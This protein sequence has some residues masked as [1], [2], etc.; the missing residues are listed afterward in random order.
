MS[1]CLWTIRSRSCASSRR[2]ASSPR[3]A[4]AGSPR[5]ASRLPAPSRRSSS[6]PCAWGVPFKARPA[7]TIRCAVTIASPTQPTAPHGTLF[8]FLNVLLATAAVREGWPP[9]DVEAMLVESDE[10]ALSF[11]SGGVTWRGRTIATDALDATRASSFA[12]L[13][14]VLVR[15]A[16]GRPRAHRTR[17]AM[18]DPTHDPRLRSW[19]ASAQAPGTDFPVQNLPFGVF[20]RAGRSL[21]DRGRDWRP[22][23]RRGR[24]G[25]RGTAGDTAPRD[26][27]RVPGAHAERA[28]G[29]GRPALTALR[30]GL[31]LLLREAPTHRAAN[32]RAGLL[33]PQV[34]AVML[35]PA[36]V[37]DYTDFYA[38]VHHATNVGAHV[39]PR[40]P[41]AAELQ[42]ESRSATTA[43]LRRSCQRHAGA[44]AVWA[45][46]TRPTAR[47]PRFGPSQTARLRARGRRLRRPRQRPRLARCPSARPRITSSACA[48]STTGRRATSRRGS[49]SRSAR[50]SRR[51]SPRRCRRGS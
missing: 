34:D 6:R 43:A 20:S 31:S 25:A 35:L 16:G 49:T 1:R 10:G 37:G 3:R 11:D 7:C 2:T 41:A 24:G 45:A 40:Q 29:A 8:G 32:V 51:T 9:S 13:R 15:R 28:D 48:W 36:T 12:Q 5:T 50:S 21:A 44:S 33:V 19:V 46:Q 42:V 27:R 4:P 14:L 22:D 23:P 38:S 26:A 39:P 17:P 47:S 30:A 18:I